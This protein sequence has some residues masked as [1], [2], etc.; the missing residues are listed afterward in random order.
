MTMTLTDVVWRERRFEAGWYLCDVV[1]HG[2]H[3]RLTVTL[4]SGD[5]PFQIHS[6]LVEC[7]RAETDRWRARALAVISNPD[8][9]SCDG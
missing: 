1:R 6:E 5:V 2:D 8:L 7:D 4:L 9:R 3:G